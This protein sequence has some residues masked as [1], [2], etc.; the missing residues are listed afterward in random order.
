MIR[1][2]LSTL[3]YHWRMNLA[4]GLGVAVSVAVLT[5][6][7]L[8]GDSVRGSLT[9]LTLDRLGRI[10]EVVAT[11]RFFHTALATE[12]AAA[13][14]F[15]ESFS[16]V[17]PAIFL[18]GSL[19]QPDSGT[20]ASQVSLWACG[21]AFWKL[22]DGEQRAPEHSSAPAEGEVFLNQPL[23]EELRVAVG[24]D[25]VV[26]LPRPTEIP[27]DSPLGKKTD[28]IANRRLKVAQVLPALGRGQFSLRPNQQAPLNAFFH[29]ADLQSALGQSPDRINAML[30]AGHEAAQAPPNE[31]EQ[32]L[33]KSL[34][35]KLTDYGLSL[36]RSERGYFNLSSER[37]LLEPVIERAALAVFESD[38]PQNAFT[39]LANYILAGEGDRGRIPYSTITAL[40][41]TDQPPLGPFKTPEG[42]P[43]DSLADDEILLNRW[44]VDDFSRQGVALKP[45]DRVRLTYFEPE[46]THG[47]VS[48][49]TQEFKLKA[50]V[51]MTGPAGDPDFTPEL[52]GVTDQASLDNW[53]PPFPY[54]PRRVRTTP[55]HDEDDRYWHDYKAT[56]KGFVS[57]ATGQKLWSSR[58][59]RTTSIRIPPADGLTEADLAERLEKEL[60]THKESLGFVF[61]PVKWQG[62]AAS[63]GT[64]DFNGLFLGFSFFIIVS[65]VMLA[66]LL[67]RLGVERRASEIGTLAAVGFSARQVRW[68]LSAEGLLV[69]LAGGALGLA[70]GLGFAWLMLAGLRDPRWWLAAVG[71]PFLQLH[72]TWQSFVIGY[73]VGAA[74]CWLAIVWSLWRMSKVSIRRLLAGEAGSGGQLVASRTWLSQT[75][76]WLSLI[77]AIGMA[78][79]A[80]RLTGE[81][82][83]GAFVG[84][85]ALVLTALLAFVWS[86][87]RSGG[88]GQLIK[89]GGKGVMRL[90]LRNA[91][92]NPGRS[93][94]TIGLVAVASFLI[95]ALSA[96]RLDPPESTADRA[97]GSGGFLLMAASDQP[98]YQ[99]LGAAAGRE[100]LG[101]SADDN[102]LLADATIVSLRVKPGD[103][104]SC[105]NLYQP[106]EPRVLGVPDALVDRGGFAWSATV[107]TTAEEEKNPW[108]LLER[109]LADGA[110]GEPHIPVILD[111][112][113][114]AYSLHLGGVGKTYP[115]S[116]GRGGQL[117][118]EVVGLLKNSI[119][120]G[121]L[122]ISEKAFLT[123]FPGISG[124]QFFLIDA[125]REKAAQVESLLERG[126]GDAGF[127]AQPTRRRLVEL[128]AVQNTY[129]STFQSLG[130]L[131]L[132]LGTLGLAVVQLRNVLE[133]RGEMALMRAT[134]FRRGLL[135]RMVL[136]ENASLLVAGL[137]VGIGAALVAVWPHLWRG[138]AALPWASLAVT[139]ALVLTT[140]LLAGLLA[141]RAA[142]VAPL[143]PALRG[144]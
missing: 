117:V 79:V 17:V 132:L 11:D 135:G 113:T 121:D 23:A 101:L 8:V 102:P 53:D 136:L 138:G 139:M 51:S 61:R 10:D 98:L 66:A 18:Q 120:Q 50:V 62:L 22:D 52:R 125:P 71:T 92:R 12:V 37:M 107:A 28:L 110:D 111:A 122:L 140:G 48:E 36:R 87:L 72:T 129:L 77:G 59:G 2:I 65:A 85:G 9:R 100:A 104:A 21:P 57:L 32:R 123:H 3:A 128:M 47:G 131:G 99:D 13:P 46:S 126:L 6:A 108:L 40:D 19:S 43:I 119:F 80:N 54:D 4:A 42:Q 137:A 83:A 86:R 95:I 63:R 41:L 56:P 76:A 39:Y 78:T 130:G 34:L 67:F 115:V 68:L 89:P 29:L 75:I 25:V 134:G 127:D 91:A 35:P 112:N 82:Q 81:A 45:G 124:Y 38:H 97:G 133:R 144:D 116:D 49:T 142:L 103:D 16:M 106:A 93:T 5:G 7:L 109:P 30:I 31:S 33:Q 141:L 94:L 88:A 105:L 90:A 84:S 24:D 1:L 58:F 69:S 27:P 60:A 73:V 118:F 114:A 44:A 55:P 15:T 14:E 64:T 20:R 143:L 70:G 96:F 26:R 74:I